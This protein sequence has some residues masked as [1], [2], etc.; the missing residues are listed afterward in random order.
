MT[1]QPIPQA[2]AQPPARSRT[3]AILALV[4]GGVLTVFGPIIGILIGSF[5]LITPALGLADTTTRLTPT[6]SIELDAGQSVFLLVPVADLEHAGYQSCTASTDGDVTATVG[7]EPA[8]ALNTLANGTRYESF[9]RVTADTHGIY[10]LSCD[11]TVDVI[12]APPFEIGTFFGPL[13][14]WTAAGLV[15]S[16][17]GI[18]LA[19][20][21]IVRLV[22]RAPQPAEAGAAR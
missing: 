16:L 17:V 4:I 10:T 7:Y 15:V 1:Q 13:G 19:I 20:I 6:A 2:A 9:A 12:T 14:S 3:T 11:T 8:S 5:A 18:V 21:G 22:S